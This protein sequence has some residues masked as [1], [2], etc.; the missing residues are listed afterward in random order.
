MITLRRYLKKLVGEL[1][2][3]KVDNIGKYESFDLFFFDES[4]FGTTTVQRRK[5]TARGIKPIGLFQQEFENTYLYGAFSPVTGAHLLYEFS[6]CNSECFEAFLK[7]LAN[8]NSK[9]LKIVVLDNA[10]WHKTRT[11]SIPD[12]IRLIYL[13]PYSPE[14]NPAEKV[15]WVLKQDIA[16][17]IFNDRNHFIKK[18]YKCI[19]KLTNESIYKLTN[20]EYLQSV[21]TIFNR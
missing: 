20:Y 3:I 13:P 8:P 12:N 7:A 6:H 14:L 11:L 9:E 18:F 21:Q 2:D 10:P 16:M 5:I 4:R 1:E 15:W 19:N 17:R